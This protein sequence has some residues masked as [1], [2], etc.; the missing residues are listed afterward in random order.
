LRA[1]D[2]LLREE[3]EALKAAEKRA[4]EEVEML[5]A[6]LAASEAEIK[7]LKPLSRKFTNDGLKKAVKEYCADEQTAETK[8]GPISGWDVSEVTS[9]RVLF[10]PSGCE[11]NTEVVRNFNGDIKRWD[12]SNVTDMFGMF[13][14]AEQFNCNLSSW[15]VEKVTDM[16]WMFTGAEK[17]DK[18]TIKGWE[19]KGKYTYNMFGECNEDL[20]LGKG[21]RKL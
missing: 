9:M 3:V 13:C 6:K 1:S 15:N 5:K 14:N 21:T 11:N 10:C 4:R 19:L 17:F 7:K 12:V 18:N 16:G 2:Q 8:Y 20:K